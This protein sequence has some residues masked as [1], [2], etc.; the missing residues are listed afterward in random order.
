MPFSKAYCQARLD[1]ATKSLDDA[2]ESVQWNS[3]NR[4]VRR[5]DQINLYQN[6][7]T[8]WQRELDR[9]SGKDKGSVSVRPGSVA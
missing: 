6:A 2:L 5:S 8:F 3:S 4:S 9:A 1:N 7:V